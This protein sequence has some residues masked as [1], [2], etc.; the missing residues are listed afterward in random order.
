MAEHAGDYEWRGE[1]EEAEI[2]LYASGESSADPAIELT[3]PAARLPGVE[4]PVFA[5][6][7]PEGF[8]WVAASPTHAAP[9]LASVPRRGVL[10]VSEAAVEDLGV[11]PDEILP[12]L[13]RHLSEISLPRLDGAGVRR[14][15]EAGVAAA[16]E[17]G[18]IEEED[19]DHFG[20]VP[21]DSD[22]LGRRSLSAGAR[23]WEI[24]PEELQVKTVGEVF[25]ADSAEELGLW[26]GT[27]AFVLDVGAGDL[28]RLALAAHREHIAGRDFGQEGVPA[29][30]VEVEEATDLLA[31]LGAAASFA[32]GRT[33]LLAYALRRALAGIAGRLSVLAAWRVGGIEESGGLIVHRNGLAAA[34]VERVISAGGN[35]AVGAGKMLGSAPPFGAPEDDGGWPW[36]EAGL[37]E[38]WARLD[39]PRG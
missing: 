24:H 22:S 15:C 7:S 18:L 9:N 6:T 34:G 11:P 25:D 27:L 16:A 31:A 36:E 21:G 19:L 13:M 12:Y 35:V 26:S 14:F 3:L 10:L 32:D 37:L 39:D 4:S 23:D 17:D 38:R 29:A 28:G 2:F 1:G 33:A 20:S 30:P 5:A 8:G